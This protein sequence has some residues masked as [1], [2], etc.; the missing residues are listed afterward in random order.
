M[1]IIYREEQFIVQINVCDRIKSLEHKALFFFPEKAFRHFKLSF[2]SVIP[3]GKL[4]CLI[5]IRPPIGIFDETAIH[6]I[7]QNSSRYNS[8][9]PFLRFHIAPVPGAIQCNS[10][11]HNLLLL[12]FDTGRCNTFYEVPLEEQEED[13]DRNYENSRRRHKVRPVNRVLV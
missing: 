3:A 13:H 10:L 1:H 12:A 8:L 2:I 11:F 5:L 7:G 9:M 6:H 4:S